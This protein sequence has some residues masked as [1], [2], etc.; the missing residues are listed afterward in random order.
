MKGLFTIDM[1]GVIKLDVECGRVLDN[2][3]TETIQLEPLNR[4][5]IIVD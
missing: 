3:E 5:V 2:M 4:N 1:Y